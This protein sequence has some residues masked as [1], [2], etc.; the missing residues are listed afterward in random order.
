MAKKYTKKT[1]RSRRKLQK[2]EKNT[3][4][5][6]IGD[7]QATFQMILPMNALMA[8]VANSIEQ[9]ASQAGLLMMKAM[10]DEEVE[11]LADQ[12]YVHNDQR[13]A[14]RWGSEEGH[15]IF[16]GRKVAI[17]RPRVRS[18]DGKEVPLK[19]YQA[20][21]DDQRMQQSVQDRIVRRVSTR[22]YEGVINDI[23][24]GYGIDKS[25]VSRQWKAASAG[26]LKEMLERKLNDLDLAVVILDGISF[27]DYLLVVALGID[28]DGHKHVLGLWPGAT[29]NTEVVGVLLDDLTERGLPTD[30]HLLFVLDGSKAL[31]KAVKKRFGKR[32]IIQRC[33]I[34]K[35]RNVLGHLPK[36]YHKIVRMKLH[37]AWN[38]TDYKEAKKQLQK[39]HDYLA[40]INIAAAHSLEEGFEQLLM[41]NRLDLPE[42]LRKV[43]CSTNIIESCFSVTKDLCRNVKRWRNADMAWRWAGT[44]LREAEKR[45]HRIKGYRNIPLLIKALGKI[46]D[47]KE[48]AA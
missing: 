46:V 10:I 33:R 27:H 18:K 35:E 9:M 37:T 21:Q 26:Q 30:S 17:E 45:F 47:A 11:Q 19:R 43:L 1:K 34:H 5:V 29:E 14:F 20:F 13:L 25:S 2:L 32:A 36:E 7:G 38:M 31:S 4:K 48:V 16:S 8:E 24:D 15:V 41:V 44:M 23:C 40:T 3:V 12:R 6:D 42:S 28:F 39:V 22:D